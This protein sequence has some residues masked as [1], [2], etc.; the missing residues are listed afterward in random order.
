MKHVLTDGGK[1]EHLDERDLDCTVRSLAIAGRIDY[2]LAYVL[3][4]DWGRKP[5]SASQ[6][7]GA[8]HRGEWLCPN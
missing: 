1:P 7:R 5:G 4:E 8:W 2:E 3:F 6:G